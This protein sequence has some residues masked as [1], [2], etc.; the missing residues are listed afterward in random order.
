MYHIK[1]M[2]TWRSLWPSAHKLPKAIKSKLSCMVVQVLGTLLLHLFL[3]VDKK[4]PC[5][6]QN[7]NASFWENDPAYERHLNSLNNGYHE[8]VL[9]D[10]EIQNVRNQEFN[11]SMQALG[12]RSCYHGLYDSDF[13]CFIIWELDA[14]ALLDNNKYGFWGDTLTRAVY[15]LIANNEISNPGSIHAC[16]GSPRD[17]DVNQLSSPASLACWYAAKQLEADAP[18]GAAGSWQFLFYLDQLPYSTTINTVITP[19][20]VAQELSNLGSSSPIVTNL[21]QFFTQKQFS[22]LSYQQWDPVKDL[23]ALGLHS[24]YQS[25]PSAEGNTNSYYDTFAIFT[26]SGTIPWCA[27]DASV[28]VPA[29]TSRVPSLF[30]F[31]GLPVAATAPMPVIIIIAICVAVLVIIIVVLGKVCH[32]HRHR[33]TFSSSTTTSFL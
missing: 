4:L 20:E 11:T 2:S 5:P 23:Y 15:N 6:L 9:S 31:T 17:C 29:V 3:V 14:I 21:A 8:V 12:L 19:A 26:V 27:G 18:S 33:L 25:F 22:G 10:I 24:F 28:V 1:A 13:S 16:V 32:M 7:L 30:A